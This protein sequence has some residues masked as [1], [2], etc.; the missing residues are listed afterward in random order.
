MLKGS[1][2]AFL[3]VE[4]AG[5]PESVSL[6]LDIRAYFAAKAMQGLAA[7][8]A[9]ERW[10][11]VNYAHMAVE[12]ADALLVALNAKPEPVEESSVPLD[13]DDLQLICRALGHMADA[14]V[15][16]PDME[17]KAR[18]LYSRLTPFEQEASNAEQETTDATN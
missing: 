1:D 14:H 12:Y 15:W 17:T 8:G 2:C 3:L 6:G 10:E 5:T 7:N 13:A 9:W 16:R 11:P 4:E 18:Q